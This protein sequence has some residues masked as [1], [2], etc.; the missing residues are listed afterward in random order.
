MLLV[1]SLFLVVR[2]GAPL[3]ASLLLVAMPFVPSSKHSLV[4]DPSTKPLLHDK[5]RALKNSSKEPRWAAETPKKAHRTSRL[6]NKKKRDA[7]VQETRSGG[8]Q[9]A[10]F[11]FQHLVV[12]AAE[13]QGLSRSRSLRSTGF[14]LELNSLSHLV[15]PLKTD[16]SSALY[17]LWRQT[18]YLQKRGEHRSNLDATC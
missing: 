7:T 2:P 1:A 15:T 6:P 18:S 4:E 16:S 13:G 11:G 17:L 5:L 10:N 14:W 8:V 12:F 9:S 3:V